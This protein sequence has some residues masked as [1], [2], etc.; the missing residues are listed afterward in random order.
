VTMGSGT[1][2]SCV[3]NFGT[4]WTSA[5]NSCSLTPANTTAAATGTTGA[6][7][8]AISTTQVTITGAN[9]TSAAYYIHCM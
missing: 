2:T 9:L 4:T 1:L 6:Y 5:P 7:V 8:S 3:I